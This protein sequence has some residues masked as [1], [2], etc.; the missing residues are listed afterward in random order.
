MVNIFF[1]CMLMEENGF[2]PYCSII[3]SHLVI[4]ISNP[5]NAKIIFHL[6]YIYNASLRQFRE[7]FIV[8]IGPV[9]S[10][11]FLIDVS[12]WNKCKLVMTGCGC[13]LD[14]AWNILIGKYLCM[15]FYSTLLLTSF[16]LRPTPLKT[17]LENRLIVVESIIFRFFSHLGCPQFR[18]SE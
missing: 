15:Y 17:K 9:K 14:I 5:F 18:L 4:R 11:Q 13:E 1:L 8:Y 12:F 7:L 3:C 6:S 2:Y 10:N 16:G